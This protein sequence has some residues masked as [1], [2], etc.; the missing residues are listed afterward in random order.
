M[1]PGTWTHFFASPNLLAQAGE[2]PLPPLLILVLAIIAGVGTVLLLPTQTREASMRKIGGALLIASAIVLAAFL[3]RWAAGSPKGGMNAYFWIFS[4]IGLVGAM[5]VITHTRPVYSALYFVLTVFA[6][7]GLFLLLWAEFMAA[8]LVLIYAGAIL[9]TYVFVI[10]LAA[11]ATPSSGPMAGLSEHDINSRDPVLAAAIGLG[12]MAVLLFVI[13]D[14]AEALAA[15]GQIAVAPPVATTTQ[16]AVEAIVTGPTQQLG[17]YLFQNHLVKLE[18]A[19]LIL[20]LAMI[21]AI[22]IA[23]RRVIEPPMPEGREVVV[24][25]LTPISDDPHS[26]PVVGTDNPRQ[27]AYPEA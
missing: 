22:V 8:A 1:P 11:E 2:T 15:P 26:I 21:G 3:F 13:F 10:M 17:V 27:K 16:P 18:L 5:R 19:G 12:L 20:T 4:A 23:R 24:S 14:R 25:P 9:V 7:A 6:T